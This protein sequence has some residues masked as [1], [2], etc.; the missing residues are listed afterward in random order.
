MGVAC[1]DITHNTFML[2]FHN[3]KFK[4]SKNHVY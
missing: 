4:D 2:K 3:R 1:Y